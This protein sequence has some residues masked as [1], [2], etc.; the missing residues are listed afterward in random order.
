MAKEGDNSSGTAAVIL[1]I[2]SIS[3]TFFVFFSL[4]SPIAGFALGI[5]GL[6]FALSQRKASKNRWSTWGIILSIVGLILNLIVI[7]GMVSIIADL[8]QS[9]Q[10]LCNAA[11]GCENIAQYLQSSQVQSQIAGY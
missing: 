4:F 5:T 8:I 6:I 10:E 11:G 3:T 1:G 2:M 7:I 9:Y